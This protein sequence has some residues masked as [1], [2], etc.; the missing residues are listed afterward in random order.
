VPFD[1]SPAGVRQAAAAEPAKRQRMKTQIRFEFRA[2]Q[3]GKPA[4]YL[5][6]GEGTG[7]SRRIAID[8]PSFWIGAGDNNNYV[9][10]DESVSWHHACILFEHADLYLCDDS[11]NGTMLNGETIHKER[12]RLNRNDLVQIGSA[13][14][15]LTAD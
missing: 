7:G 2:P 1:D 15:R 9:I 14:L 11:R 13:V 6:A 10:E 3:P 5:V 4:A 12:R 8:Q